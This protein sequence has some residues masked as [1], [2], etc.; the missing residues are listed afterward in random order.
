MRDKMLKIMIVISP[1]NSNS[2]YGLPPEFKLSLWTPP[3]L[4]SKSAYGL[5]LWIQTQ[6][7][8][9]PLNS[10]SA[11][12]IPPEIKIRLTDFLM[13]SPLNS[14]KSSV[15]KAGGIIILLVL[16]ILQCWVTSSVL[17]GISRNYSYLGLK[18]YLRFHLQNPS[19]FTSINEWDAQIDIQKK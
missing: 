16:Y 18:I 7:M 13:D 3:P 19:T 17:H 10:N 14:H 2:V 12:G 5:P 15:K 9:S 8:D 4:N 1:L 11:N 6:P